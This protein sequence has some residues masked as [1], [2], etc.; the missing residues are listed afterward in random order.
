MKVHKLSSRA[1]GY[2]FAS[3]SSRLSLDYRP[4]SAHP[5]IDIDEVTLPFGDESQRSNTD[6]QTTIEFHVRIPQL[7]HRGTFTLVNNDAYHHHL[8]GVFLF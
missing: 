2:P 8:R 1:T 3:E 7:N 6:L 5:I 4:P